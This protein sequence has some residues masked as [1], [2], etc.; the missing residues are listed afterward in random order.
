MVN[1]ITSEATLPSGQ[2]VQFHVGGPTAEMMFNE[3][4]IVG[5]LYRAS[6]IA[7]FA[8][9]LYNT[10]I[11]DPFGEPG[12][13][14]SLGYYLSS[15]TDSRGTLSLRNDL[16]SAT[17]LPILAIDVCKFYIGGG[18]GGGGGGRGLDCT[19]E[20]QRLGRNS[21]SVGVILS[22]SP[23]CQYNFMT[24]SSLSA[25]YYNHLYLFPISMQV[26]RALLMSCMLKFVWEMIVWTG[27]I[28]Y[29]G[30]H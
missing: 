13:P 1:N 25:T 19:D 26:Y 12:S 24:C 14:P 28:N 2:R 21:L 27:K 16:Q 7:M 30:A 3:G 4:D 23:D 8:P 17:F 11:I 29:F 20:A 15:R 10:S 9:Y 22:S 18:G 6:N 5:V